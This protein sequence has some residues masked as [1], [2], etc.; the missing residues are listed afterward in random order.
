[1]SEAGHHV[2]IACIESN[3]SW[4]LS[5]G[6][7]DAGLKTLRAFVSDLIFLLSL[8]RRRVLQFFPFF[9]FELELCDALENHAMP[10]VSVGGRADRQWMRFLWILRQRMKGSLYTI[11]RASLVSCGQ[12][13]LTSKLRNTSTCSVYKLAD[14]VRGSR[15]AMS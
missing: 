15:G 4:V 8:T 1:M 6:D 14:L 13:T 7:W 3:I 5:S 12:G 2:Y 9:S 10:Q 11:V